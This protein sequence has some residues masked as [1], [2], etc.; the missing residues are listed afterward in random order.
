MNLTLHQ[1]K[2]LGL[3]LS[4][5]VLSDGSTQLDPDL[6]NARER[7]RILMEMNAIPIEEQ[8]RAIQESIDKLGETEF[9]R[10]QVRGLRMVGPLKT[11]G[12]WSVLI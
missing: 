4:S 2:S 6:E 3:L 11:Q 12:K 10:R 5:P 9:V 1:H 8:R 7:I